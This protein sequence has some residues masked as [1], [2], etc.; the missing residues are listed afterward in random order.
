MIPLFK[1]CLG[2]EELAALAEIFDTGWVGL[3]PRTA[4][5]EERF[6]A[7][8]GTKH[9]VGVNSCTAALHLALM[10][11][12]I[13]PGDEVIVPSLTFVSTAHAVSYVGATPVFCDV[14]ADTFCIDVED[15]NRKITARTRAVIPVHLGG[16]PCDM[17]AIWDAIG[18]RDIKVIEDAAESAGSEYKGKKAGALGHVGCF[19]FEAKKNMTTG[20]GGMITTDDG[21]IVEKLRRLRWVGINRD[22]WKRFSSGSSYTWHYEV[23]ELGYKYNMNDIQAAI[24]LVQLRKLDRFSAEKRRIREMY[25][26]ELSD[27]PWLECPVERSW[28]R[29]AYW[30]FII[31]VNQ[32]DRFI[33]HMSNNDIVTGVHFMPVH[34]HPYYLDSKPILPVTDKVWQRMVSLP[35]FVGMN[36]DQFAEVVTVVRSFGGR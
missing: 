26:A 33:E 9:A 1:P 36:D 18:E 30:L 24:G 22:T 35:L 6:A 31:K 16:H 12:D 17:D 34:L 20:D 8:I 32:R 29:G 5:F 3:G 7:Y 4:E 10:V 13:G 28:A 19:S 21:A 15:M 2:K 14:E 23:A 11:F 27:V 25:T